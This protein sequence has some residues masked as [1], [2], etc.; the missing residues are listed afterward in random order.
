MKKPRIIAALAAAFMLTAQSGAFMTCAEE[1]AKS[2]K[3]NIDEEIYASI[4]KNNSSDDK[5]DDGIISEEEMQSLSYITL[6][7]TIIK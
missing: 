5:S 7:G 3:A 6:D 1:T 4:L 2:Q